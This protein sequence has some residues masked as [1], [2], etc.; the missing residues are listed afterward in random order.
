MTQA[1]LPPGQKPKSPAS[2]CLCGIQNDY[3][4]SVIGKCYS[5]AAAALIGLAES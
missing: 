2:T 1:R 3:G 5:G 4:E